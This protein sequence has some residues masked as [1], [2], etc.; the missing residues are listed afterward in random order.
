MLEKEMT[1]AANEGQEAA[2]VDNT[3]TRSEVK[4]TLRFLKLFGR[5]RPTLCFLD[6]ET[7]RFYTKRYD[8]PRKAAWAAKW[9]CDEM[10]RSVY[11]VGNGHRMEEVRK[12]SKEDIEQCIGIWIDVD[13]TG[14]DPDVIDTL[15]HYLD[16]APTYIA[17]TGGGYQA[18]WRFDEFTSDRSDC[19]AIN[20]WVR[21][22]FAEV[23]PGVDKNCWTCGHIWRLP[24]TANRKPGR[25]RVCRTVHADWSARL[26]VADAE[27]GSPPAVSDVA[28]VTFESQDIW[29]LEFVHECLAEWSFRM[30]THR[31]PECPTRSEHEFKFIGSVLHDRDP[32]QQ[33]DIDLVAACL[34]AVPVDEYSVSHRAYFNS[35]GTPRK[36]PEAHVLRQI[37]SWL[38]KNGR[39]VQC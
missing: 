1:P 21:D 20:L 23:L 34:L 29:T 36:D 25:D 18:H 22:A 10:G 2:K 30:L 14:E 13:D 35:D 9:W 24:G 6:H 16:W 4:A 38:S 8:S 37:R 31:P 19:E 15:L 27:R 32:I 17:F 26:P 28:P 12:P 7:R 33:C 39:A 5:R 3:S 11:F